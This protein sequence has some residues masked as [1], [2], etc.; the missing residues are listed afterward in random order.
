MGKPSAQDTRGFL[1]RVNNTQRDGTIRRDKVLVM[2]TWL[3]T[4]APAM[5]TFEIVQELPPAAAS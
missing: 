1:Q 2:I 5:L 3:K 4:T